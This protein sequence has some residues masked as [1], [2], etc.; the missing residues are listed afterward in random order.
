MEKQPEPKKS[1]PLSRREVQLITRLR[2]LRS[3]GQQRAEVELDQ[4]D[5]PRVRESGR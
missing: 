3:L 4:G 5:G 1:I 2:Q